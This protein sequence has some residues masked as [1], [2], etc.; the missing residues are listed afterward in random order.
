MADIDKNIN[1]SPENI[2]EIISKLGEYQSFTD[3]LVNSTKTITEEL[4]KQFYQYEKQL[5]K[6]RDFVRE[7]TALLAKQGALN[8]AHNKDLD[9]LEKISSE[10]DQKMVAAKKELGFRLQVAHI[11]EQNLIIGKQQLRVYMDSAKVLQTAAERESKTI[12]ERLLAGKLSQEE[13]Q[14]L[15]TRKALL[16]ELAK[17]AE[18][19]R[20]ALSGEVALSPTQI[21]RLGTEVSGLQG[22]AQKAMETTG[23]GAMKKLSKTFE[24]GVSTIGK[25]VGKVMTEVMGSI[26]KSIANTLLKGGIAGLI[27]NSLLKKQ[28]MVVR[29]RTAAAEL[30]RQMGGGFM[31]ALPG[32]AS[33]IEDAF[34]TLR[35]DL[36]M[37]ADQSAKVMGDLFGTGYIKAGENAA[38]L[39]VNAA[40]LSR[41]FG[42]TI[43]QVGSLGV[44]FRFMT[45]NAEDFASRMRALQIAAKDSNIPFNMLNKSFQDLMGSAYL[46]GTSVDEL[47][48]LHDVIGKQMENLGKKIGVTSYEQI[49]KSVGELVNIQDKGNEG[50]KAY[51]GN[52]MSGKKGL[53]ALFAWQY[54]KTT[55][56]QRTAS[57]GYQMVRGEGAATERIETLQRLILQSIQRFGGG[58]WMGNDPKVFRRARFEFE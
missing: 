29:A 16:D 14:R 7:Q 41:E 27:I 4:Q 49:T 44:S 9:I 45:G 54:G 38:K 47:V 46:Y 12:K 20:K 5:E 21:K 51:L 56:I 43:S 36:Y 42:M 37:T 34:S 6:V 50:M 35:K 17:K 30:A 10:T 48:K 23:P 53:Q 8:D 25:S 31:K 22:Q 26:M 13:S 11:N 24:K 55:E 32:T 15:I 18:L 52:L 28:E 1:I 33:Q 39:S 3:S 58:V 57:G 40:I 2:D 19:Y